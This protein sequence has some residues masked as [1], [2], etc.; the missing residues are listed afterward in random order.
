MRS[1]RPHQQRALVFVK[2][3]LAEGR[4]R[5]MLQ[6]P[7]GFG[8]TLVG[9]MIAAGALAKG[10]RAVFVVP[11][12]SLIDQ[13]VQSFALD[14]ITDVG[15][16]QAAHPMTDPSRPVQIASVQSLQARGVDRLPP[17]H[18]VVIDEAHRNFE[19]IQ[20]WMALPEWKG[21]PFVGLSATPWARGLGKH[22]DALVVGETCQGLI[23]KGFLAPFRV[24]APAHPD[25][26][27]VATERGDYH[28]GQL[29]EVMADVV[30]VAGVVTT[31]LEKGEGR[32]TLCFAVNRAHAAKLQAEFLRAGVPCGY[33]DAYTKPID[34]KAIQGQFERG[35]L[36]VVV[37][38]GTLTTGVDWDVRCI[39]LARPT[40]SKM[41]YVQMVGRGLRTAPGKADCL[42][43]D[44]S[45]TTLR[46]GFVTDIHQDELCD[47]T[48]DGRRARRDADEEPLPKEC[49]KC[50]FLRPPKVAECPACGFKA[51]RQTDIVEADGELVEL[52]GKKS[53]STPAE[54][55]AWYSGL[56]HIRDERGY[57]PN[58]PDVIYKNKHGDW[59]SRH[60]LSPRPAPPAPDVIGYV[61]AQQIR[62][63]K[64]QRA[65]S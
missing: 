22:Y 18:V 30:L 29:A 32:P 10:R 50:S 5:V 9:A 27:G 11:A 13:T 59:P 38:I 31:W 63:S 65:A 48:A 52:R 61:T 43:L 23:D 17:A 7:T 45:D 1:P 60:G 55:Q 40:K 56:I 14:G 42:V 53:E 41:L 33:V 6:A 19:F 3:H 12:I 4:K 15:V 26:T 36:K 21:V 2:A 35:E 8:K 44:H 46:L 20:T 25:L 37:N 16:I 57:K 51:Q 24:F 49:A 34:R 39:V 47:G 54:K 58:W 64:R 28:E 62:W